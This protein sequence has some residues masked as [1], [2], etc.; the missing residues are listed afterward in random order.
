MKPEDLMRELIRKYPHIYGNGQYKDSY[1]NNNNPLLRYN[2][3]LS[4]DGSSGEAITMDSTSNELPRLYRT[5]AED[6]ENERRRRERL[7]A[8]N[9][10]ALKGKRLKRKTKTSS[11]ELAMFLAVS[12][13]S[14]KNFWSTRLQIRS[15]Q[16]LVSVTSTMIYRALLKI[17][18]MPTIKPGRVPGD[19]T[20][21]N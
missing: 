20:R 2:T 4:A 3:G 15:L 7:E 18:K 5:D 19:A 12:V 13:I 21:A 1:K 16:V 9:P 6:D 8:V 17:E 14:V 10:L 11:N